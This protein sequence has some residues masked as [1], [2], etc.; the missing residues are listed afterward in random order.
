MRKSIKHL[1]KKLFLGMLMASLMI[2]GVAA[3]DQNVYG[4]AGKITE[5]PRNPEDGDNSNWLTIQ[6]EDAGTRIVTADNREVVAVDNYGGIYLDGDVYVKGK[7]LDAD[8]FRL[9]NGFMYLLLVTSII[10]N[11][12]VIVKLKK[13]NK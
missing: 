2:G 9:G 6:S 8:I 11:I 13:K 10:L 5:A 3:V 7:L 4:T 12:I 1:I